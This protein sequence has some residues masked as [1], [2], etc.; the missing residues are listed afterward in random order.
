[1]A[2]EK[3][4]DLDELY[5]MAMIGLSEEQIAA[6]LG[7]SVATMGRRKKD[8]E[9]FAETLKAGKAAGIGK[10]TNALFKGAVEGD[11]TAAQIFFLKNRAKWSDRQEVE[12][13]GTVGVDVQLDAAIEALK[14]AGI[15]PSSL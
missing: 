14:D 4:I 13:S 12:H 1:M 8:D 15:D 10:V 11:K 9:T 2:N 5:R 6:S 3:Q 7:I